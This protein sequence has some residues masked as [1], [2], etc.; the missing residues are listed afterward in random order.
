MGSSKHPWLTRRSTVWLPQAGQ[1]RFY[2]QFADTSET[3][4]AGTN[5]APVFALWYVWNTALCRQHTLPPSD[6]AFSHI[7][8]HFSSAVRYPIMLYASS[9]QPA[10]IHADL[11]TGD[12]L[13]YCEIICSL[14][15]L[16]ALVHFVSIAY[17]GCMQEARRMLL[18]QKV[19]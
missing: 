15:G 14:C 18:T 8:V 9:V 19:I 16:T 2:S 1:L 3:T 7:S 5:L 10:L 4:F 17:S 11:F 12:I 6:P 13:A